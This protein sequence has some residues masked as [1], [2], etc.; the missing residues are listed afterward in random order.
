[1]LQADLWSPY[2][3]WETFSKRDVIFRKI[4]NTNYFVYLRDSRQMRKR[5]KYLKYLVESE[6]ENVTE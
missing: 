6:K 1:M 3:K 5:L 4:T 2:V